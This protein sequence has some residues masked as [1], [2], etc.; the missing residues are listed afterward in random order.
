MKTRLVLI[1]FFGLIFFAAVHPIINSQYIHLMH[2]QVQG[3]RAYE[4]AR[5][6]AFGQFPV[7]FV[8]NLGF[9]YGYP[10]FNYYAPLP[11]YFAAAGMFLGL[12][13][14]YA[15]K[16]MMIIGFCLAGISMFLLGKRIWGTTGGLL[17]ATLYTLAP[18]HAVQLYV[19]GSIGEMYVF[20]LLPLIVLGI[21]ELW[22][23]DRK[24]IFVKIGM[25]ALAC[26][27]LSHT[28]SI[29]MFFSLLIPYLILVIGIAL[30]KKDRS[31]LIRHTTFFVIPTAITTFFWLP[32]IAE[33]KYIQLAANSGNDVDYKL[34][35][36]TL[37]QLWSS[38]WGY[39]GSA[40]TPDKDGMSFMIGKIGLILGGITI[41]LF[42]LRVYKKQATNTVNRASLL[43][44][45]GMFLT[46]IWLITASSSLVWKSIPFFQLIQFPWRFLVY[47]TLFVSLISGGILTFAP[48]LRI[49]SPRVKFVAI[50]FIAYFLLYPLNP[51]TLKTK[52]FNPQ[53]DY[54][55]SSSQ[56]TDQTHLRYQASKIS[57]E[58]MPKGMRT[59]RTKDEVSTD[60][61]TCFSQCI[62]KD[63]QFTPTKYSFTANMVRTANI[64]L[65][66]SYFPEFVA[67]VDG[68][69]EKTSIGVNNALGVMV[70]Q[71]SHK[72]TFELIDTPLRLF[73]NIISVVSLALAIFYKQIY[74]KLPFYVKQRFQVP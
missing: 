25:I 10:L 65:E 15:T 48:Y 27:I 38:P 17:S 72:I 66:K 70:P 51:G 62:I 67:T 60:G 30:K 43:V 42:G 32:A 8:Q 4:M 46:A 11:Y 47:A 24:N 55:F 52:F 37:M 73:A 16:I 12:N 5:S 54:K 6:L 19:R 20:G 1:L 22:R 71:G 53:G 49:I 63:I 45:L 74:R 18:Y 61:M 14:I 9:G 64:F 7:R 39:G 2:D 44:F 40:P 56:I 13:V 31:L 29:I 23:P 21:Y 34:H 28:V 3:E 68:K 57:S 41:F 58:Y 59:P 50:L 33:L 69:K 35:F 36:K 26:L